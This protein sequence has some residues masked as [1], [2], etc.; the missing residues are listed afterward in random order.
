MT[1]ALFFLWDSTA[2]MP[3][4][5]KRDTVWECRLGGGIKYN[6][7]INWLKGLHYSH[8]IGWG[9]NF[10]VCAVNWVY[11]RETSFF[12]SCTLHIPGNR[13]ILFCKPLCGVVSFQP[14]SHIPYLFTDAQCNSQ[15]SCCCTRATCLVPLTC[16]GMCQF[17]IDGPWLLCWSVMQRWNMTVS[18]CTA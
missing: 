14:A 2:V 7:T 6:H 18:P 10:F 4:L 12:I 1:L 8:F 9:R 15:V 16:R 3:G 13:L 11:I 17:V 5:H